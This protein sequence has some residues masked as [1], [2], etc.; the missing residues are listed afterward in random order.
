MKKKLVAVFVFDALVSIG[1]I[2]P[3]MICLASWNISFFFFFFTRQWGLLVIIKA[4]TT[5]VGLVFYSSFVSS[6]C[7]Q[8]DSSLLCLLRFLIASLFF[9][10]SLSVIASG[11]EQTQLQKKER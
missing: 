1:I 2:L 3:N 5:D 9:S 8:V 4:I 7:Y 10:L 6:A 11:R